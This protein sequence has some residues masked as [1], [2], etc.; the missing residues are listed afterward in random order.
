MSLVRVVVLV[1]LIG[2]DALP[3][4]VSFDRTEG[5]GD[6]IDSCICAYYDGTENDL[7]LEITCTSGNSTF[8]SLSLFVDPTATTEVSADLEFISA[9]QPASYRA[10]AAG[11]VDPLSEPTDASDTKVI[12]DVSGI[13]FRWAEQD[14]CNVAQPCEIDSVHIL[15]GAVHMGHGGCEDYYATLNKELM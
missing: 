3:E 8:D 6:G 10:G 13:E 11:R 4:D 1:A 5:T 9:I 14:A 7:A 2:C 15:G 12:R